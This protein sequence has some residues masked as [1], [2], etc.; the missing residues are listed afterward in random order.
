L[1]FSQIIL[2]WYDRNARSLPWR[3][4]HDPYVIWVSE[5]IFQQTRIEQGTG[6]F[7]R[8][9]NRFPTLADLA[10][11]GEDEV[12]R[13][14]QG[15]GYYSRARNM[16]VTARF[17]QAEL[18]G[19]FPEDFD[20]IRKLK[21]IGDYTA[22][23]IASICFG[24]VHAAVDGNVYRVLSRAFADRVPVDSAA[25]KVHYKKL[26]QELISRDR[27]GDFNE[28]M[29]D[30][31]ATV[32][33]PRSPLCDACPLNASCKARKQSIQ[34]EL[35][36]K[37]PALK[38]SAS[39]M[40]YFLVHPGNRIVIRKRI[41]AGIWKGLYE[42]PMVPGD[43]NTADLVSECRESYGLEIGTV[44]EISRIRHILS[45]T[46]LDIR[47]YLAG[48]VATGEPLGEGLLSVSPGDVGNYP[49]PKPLVD[50]L[51]GL[52]DQLIP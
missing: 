38:R 33:K 40:N 47:F 10:S 4:S 1:E 35:P 37:S 44:K 7:L 9:M 49:F 19:R 2:D 18:S 3:G 14:W 26:A 48:T 52:E 51:E 34:A 45:H 8:F 46:E 15:L 20:E 16:L 50:F 12:L 21:G 11:A 29:M 27:P 31:G 22:S 36:V 23:C 17:I 42:F 28:A 30:L 5:I 13:L 24:K 41:G 32:C 39:V 43:L 25:G 6:Y